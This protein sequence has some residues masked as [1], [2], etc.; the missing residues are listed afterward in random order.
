MRFLLKRPFRDIAIIAVVVALAPAAVLLV[1]RV[2]HPPAS[3]FMTRK[4]AEL[5]DRHPGR[6]IRHQWVG[7]DRIAAC[8]PL[9]AVAGED[10]TFPTNHGFVWSSIARALKHNADGGVVRGASTITQ[11]TAKNLFLWPAK[12]YIRKA[13]EAYITVWMDLL[14]SKRRVLAV[15]LNIAQFSDTA[16]GVQA[17]A[18]QLFHTPAAKLSRGECAALAAVLP[19]P[20]KYDAAH[21]GRYLTRRKAWILRQMRHLGPHYLAPA[22]QQN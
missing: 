20:D 10:Q 19:A 5:H 4:A 22:L 1:F 2:I 8:M 21:P 13:I 18:Q 6:T 17:A 12:S 16:F 3:A 9:A 15:Y 11:Q 14:W 7:L